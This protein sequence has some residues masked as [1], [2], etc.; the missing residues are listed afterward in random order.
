MS[1]LA[2]LSVCA[3]LAKPCLVQHFSDDGPPSGLRFDI[4][5][6]GLDHSDGCQIWSIQWY[7]LSLIDCQQAPDRTESQY[8]RAGPICGARTGLAMP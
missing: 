1:A 5:F 7:K 6:G 8:G 3:A 2:I 4:P